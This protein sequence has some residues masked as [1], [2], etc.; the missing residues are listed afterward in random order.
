[1]RDRERDR[2]ESVVIG[3]ARQNLSR[4]LFM[5]ESF[6]S[7][8]PIKKERSLDELRWNFQKPVGLM[9]QITNPLIQMTTIAPCRWLMLA[10]FAI[11]GLLFADDESKFFWHGED[12]LPMSSGTIKMVSVDVHIEGAEVDGHNWQVEARYMLANPTDDTLHVSLA[13]PMSSIDEEFETESRTSV[14]GIEVDYRN[15]ATLDNEESHL[16]GHYYLVEVEFLPNELVMVHHD[17]GFSGMYFEVEYDTRIG[18]LWV[19]SIDSARYTVV[20]Y[21]QL[22]RP[23]NSLYTRMEYPISSTSLERIPYDSIRHQVEW[24]EPPIE[25]ETLFSGESVRYI[26]KTTLV[27]EK[28]NWIPETEFLITLSENYILNPEI[29]TVDSIARFYDRD[30]S[31]VDVFTKWPIEVQAQLFAC[32]PDSALYAWK[33]RVYGTYG[34][35]FSD[36]N[37]NNALY[38]PRHEDP[39]GDLKPTLFYPFLPFDNYDEMTL[40]HHDRAVLSL[41]DRLLEQR[42]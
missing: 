16:F 35:V 21:N 38:E 3:I 12:V 39:G 4:I 17:Y 27:F 7:L 13:F 10:I 40:T 19:G 2:N 36:A 24:F 6:Q 33:E 5:T 29:C 34:R 23:T 8:N 18:G 15:C 22:Y 9:K 20:V 25:Q 11:P 37:I 14:R 30:P 42:R 41:I 32:R 1:M 31:M 26:S 28:R